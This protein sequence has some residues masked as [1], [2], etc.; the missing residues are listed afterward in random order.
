MTSLH[1]HSRNISSLA[2]KIKDFTKILIAYPASPPKN[3]M[4]EINPTIPNN[5]TKRPMKALY[6][7]HEFKK[8]W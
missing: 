3:A 2:G 4:V 1:I 5:N 8:F 7:F 6:D